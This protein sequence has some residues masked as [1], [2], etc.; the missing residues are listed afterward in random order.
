MGLDVY[1]L[2]VSQT[3]AL[4]IASDALSVLNVVFSFAF[5]VSATCQ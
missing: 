2:L 4:D 3:G 5:G 1:G